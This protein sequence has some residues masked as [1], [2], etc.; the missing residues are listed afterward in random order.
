MSHPQ[1]TPESP[2]PP[3]TEQAATPKLVSVIA[4]C[5]NERHYITEFCRNLAAMQLPPDWSLEVLIADG[6]SDDGTRELLDAWCRQDGRFRWVD[7]PQ[8]IV[9]TGLNR[10]VENARG[11]VIVRLDIHSRYAPDYL[12]QCLTELAASGADNVGGAWCAEGHTP[13]QKAVAAAFQSPWVAGG[14]RSRDVHYNGEVDTVYLGC[15]PRAT[16]ARVGGFDES[17]VRN[18]DDEHNLRIRRAGGRI[19]QSSRIQSAYFPRAQL[20]QVLRQ[21]AQ[22][23]YWK[24]FVMKKHGQPAA[25]RQLVPAVFVMALVVC[26]VLA[27]S[28]S[29]WPLAA[30]LLAYAVLMVLALSGMR[31]QLDAGMAARV[32]AVIAA[33]HLGYGWGSICGWRDIL[34]RRG[35]QPAWG[36]L[37]R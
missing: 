36:A 9:S 20:R 19:W 24:P 14:A 32:V 6:N 34:L 31:A 4:P 26:L 10:C 37:T 11:A 7:N 18:Q 16:L 22:Y 35:P 2:W 12:V 23:G 8:R 15:W 27:I 28:V 5:R 25:L 3:V 1:G 29:A 33:Y 21:Y 30:L 17:L 13:M